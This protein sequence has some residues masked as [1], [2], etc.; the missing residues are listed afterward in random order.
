M[1]KRENISPGRQLIEFVREHKM[2]KCPWSRER[3]GRINDWG[4]EL[5]V[6]GG[7]RF[8]NGDFGE[9]GSYINEDLY[10]AAIVEENTSAI[11]ALEYTG[12][13]APF[14]AMDVT[15][16]SNGP[17]MAHVVG[18]RRRC[19]L[20]VGFSFL[21]EGK[22]VKVTSFGNDSSYLVA[23]SYPPY[24]PPERCGECGRDKCTHDPKAYKPERIYKITVA[25]LRAG[26]ALERKKNPK[27]PLCL[28]TMA[29]GHE[30][31]DG[32]HECERHN[33]H[34]P[35]LSAKEGKRVSMQD[36]RPKWLLCNKCA[37]EVERD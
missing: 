3:V 35:I 23:C 10:A 1:S 14:I 4:V 8:E 32:K 37:G 29:P 30:I 15:P 31:C 18:Q 17:H 33:C 34:K 7:F 21:W 26:R 28:K 5:A 24:V 20:A 16:A 6:R 19:R 22:R 11:Q 9:P 13:R 27:C 2:E 36:W 12:K 25:D